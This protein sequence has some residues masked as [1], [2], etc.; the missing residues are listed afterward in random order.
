MVSGVTS[1]T[2]EDSAAARASRET[3]HQLQAKTTGVPAAAPGIA[4]AISD[5]LPLLAG[6]LGVASTS[7]PD[8]SLTLESNLPLPLGVR[9]Q[10][11]RLRGILH[12]ARLFDPLDEALPADTREATRTALEHDFGDFDDVELS[13]AFNFESG[14]FGR[15][16]AAYS[17]LYGALF[18][19]AWSAAELDIK[20]LS[21]RDKLIAFTRALRGLESEEGACGQVENAERIPMRA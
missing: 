15:S 18:Q 21:E 5:F 9:P 3:D 13:L 8:G 2:V 19:Q 10:R 20:T 12:R 16:F 14:H 7:N 11:A 6:G 17:E 1:F 4:S